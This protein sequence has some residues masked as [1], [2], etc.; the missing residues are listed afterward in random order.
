MKFKH[1][2]YDLLI[3]NKTKQLLGGNVKALIIGSAPISE[4]VI[5]FLKIAF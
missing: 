3:F 4:E 1:W 5:D 2:L